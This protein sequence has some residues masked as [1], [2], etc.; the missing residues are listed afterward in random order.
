[1]AVA[2]PQSVG[3]PQNPFLLSTAYNM[4]V[5]PPTSTVSPLCPSP[6]FVYG[7]PQ[8]QPFG[9]SVTSNS[10]PGTQGIYGSYIPTSSVQVQPSSAQ[11]AFGTTPIGTPAS[12]MASYGGQQAFALPSLGAQHSTNLPNSL[13]HQ[14]N[15]MNFLINLQL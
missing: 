1:M 4:G 9:A 2:P 15:S 10:V 13:I 14:Q 6:A 12:L 8:I 5:P 3:T 11:M 7:A